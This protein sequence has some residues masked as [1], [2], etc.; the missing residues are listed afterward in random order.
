MPFEDGKTSIAPKVQGSRNLH[1][2]LPNDLDFFI[3][4]SSIAGIFGSPGQSNFAAGNAYMDAPAHHRFL[5]GLKA[6]SLDLGGLASVGLLPENK[7]LTA[8]ITTPGYFMPISH[9]EL[10]AL[11]HVS[12]SWHAV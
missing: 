5:R 7:T 8:R 6:A 2:L 1:I 9:A 3:L 4:L 11:L 12:V 10:L